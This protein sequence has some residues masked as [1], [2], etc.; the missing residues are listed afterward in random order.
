VDH[1]SFRWKLPPKKKILRFNQ[2]IFFVWN[3]SKPNEIFSGVKSLTDYSSVPVNHIRRS[4]RHH[5]QNTFFT[6]KNRFRASCPWK[7]VTVPHCWLE[8]YINEMCV[9][10][11][12]LQNEPSYSAGTTDRLFIWAILLWDSWISIKVNSTNV[13][14][15]RNPFNSQKQNGG[16]DS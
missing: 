16:V 14:E 12:L 11:S 5:L 1:K 10:T 3:L 9:S 4:R 2:R 8:P 7:R 13:I 15:R 6:L